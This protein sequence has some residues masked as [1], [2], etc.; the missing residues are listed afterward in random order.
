MLAVLVIIAVFSAVAIVAAAAYGRHRHFNEVDRFH[1]AS[2]LTTEWARG[3]VTR[4]VLA[5]P[6]E[7]PAERHR[8]ERQSADANGQAG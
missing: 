7:T 4:P 5:D 1:R 6:D 2:R 3:G 8:A